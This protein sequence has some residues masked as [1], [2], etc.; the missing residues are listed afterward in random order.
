MITGRPPRLADRLLRR[1]L[2]EGMRGE[3][4]RGDL[5]EEFHARPSRW[6]FWRQTLSLVVR[7]GMR[8]GSPA[9]ARSDSMFETI[10]NDVRYAARSYA[11]TPTFT[12]AVLTTLALGIGAST[13]I[14]SMVNAILLSRCR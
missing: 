14:F 4:I 7:Y 2:P 9:A 1:V 6:W 5:L 13:A 10:W 3:T 11:K 12:L 8:R